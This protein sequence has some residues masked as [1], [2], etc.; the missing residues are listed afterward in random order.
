[1]RDLRG[2]L[3]REKA[4]IGVLLTIQEP[5]RPMTTEAASAGFYESPW[6]TKHPRLQIFTVA[7]LL[8]GEMPSFPP[9]RDI[10]THKK[11]KRFKP[12]PGDV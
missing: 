3:D 12:K 6:G 11:A 1:M 5:T 8:D 4:S 9:S 7:Q 2:V 10:R